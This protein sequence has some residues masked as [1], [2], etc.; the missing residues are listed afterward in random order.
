[1]KKV[2]VVVLILL[3]ISI[4]GLGGLYAYDSYY[5]SIGASDLVNP[6]ITVNGQH[7]E[8]TGSSWTY[9]VLFKPEGK[10]VVSSH[11]SEPV[12][13]EGAGEPL[14]IVL[15]ENDKNEAT[16]TF[17]G[18]LVDSG[19]VEDVSGYEFIEE[20]IY[21]Y[22]ITLYSSDEEEGYG[23]F[24]YS[25]TYNYVK[26]AIPPTVSISNTVVAQGDALSIYIHN[27]PE[28]VVPE[29]TSDL[30]ST[31]FTEVEG[32]Y[33][34]I[35]PT[36]YLVNPGEY[37]ATL[38]AG[39]YTED[40]NIT[41]TAHSY[42]TQ[43]FEMDSSASSLGD[44]ASANAEY[45]EIIHPLYQTK[46]ENRYWEGLFLMPAEG[47]ISSEYGLVRYINGEFN[48]YHGGIDIAAPQDTPIIAPNHAKVEYAG[49]LQL[50]GNTIVLDYGGG[51]KAYFFHLY[52]LN[53]ETGDMVEKGQ[54]IGGIG[55]T[56]FS[57][58]NHLHYQLQIEGYAMNPWGTF[59]G[60][61]G[62]FED[63]EATTTIEA[64]G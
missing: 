47:R 34:A 64:V 48:G 36:G 14:E 15:P 13:F 45:R 37:S 52:S 60:T 39:D 16:V 56:G 44:S 27:L 11:G 42:G 7:V 31:L 49:F 51:L 4:A 1:M 8:T 62:I 2:F 21:R 24:T 19:T 5:N 40:L 32:V 57:T 63:E 18:E 55:T 25:I 30:G 22:E 59:D 29:L 46:D 26:P 35:I 6:V 41:V 43:S 12:S 3:V 9:P 33:S 50:S 23:S 61:S 58:G 10:L 54:H 38:T 20:G 53:C 17:N 28:G